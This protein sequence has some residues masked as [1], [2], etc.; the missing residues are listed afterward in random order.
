MIFRNSLDQSN[1]LCFHRA[2]F[3]SI[4]LCGSSWS[5]ISEGKATF[6]QIDVGYIVIIVLE[7]G[8]I[9]LHVHFWR[10]DCVTM[11]RCFHLR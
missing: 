9:G 1:L 5:S 2:V 4:C 10:I 6:I 7:H 11:L 8:R 3:G